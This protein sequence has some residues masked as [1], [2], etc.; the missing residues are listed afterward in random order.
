[1]NKTIGALVVVILLVGAAIG[2]YLM[3]ETVPEPQL[4][5]PP[6]VKVSPPVEPVS[7][8]PVVQNVLPP[9]PQ[10][11]DSDPVIAEALSDMFGASTFKKYFLPERIIRNIVVT[12]DNLP[13]KTVS[14]KLFPVKPV[15]GKFLVSGDEDNLVISPKNADRYNAYVHITEMI[16]AGKLVGIYSR[17]SPLFQKAYQELGYPNSSFNERLITVI[18]HLIDA[19]EPKGTVK[20]VQPNVVYVYADSAM[21]AESAGRKIMMRMGRAN[22]AKVKSKLREIRRELSSQFSKQLSAR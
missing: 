11:K 16:D 7:S 2:Y 8:P 9:L 3:G 10:L 18:D 4:A 1:M 15:G 20:L 6:L 12:V 22:E 14:V 17:F 21:E 13:R 5:P 19:P